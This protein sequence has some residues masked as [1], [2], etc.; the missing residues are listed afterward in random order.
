MPR[1]V[2]L[3]FLLGLS[4][5]LVSCEKPQSQP[6]PLS[7]QAGMVIHSDAIINPGIYHLPGTDS[8]GRPLV[9]IEGNGITVDFNGSEMRGSTE[10]QL[11]NQY[12]GLAVLVR[13]SRNVTIRNLKARGY[14]IALMAE[15]SDSLLLEHCDFSYNFRQRLHSTREREDLADWL[16]YHNNEA[17]EWLRYGAAVYLKKCNHATVRHLT[18]TGGQNGLMLAECNDGLFYNN[19]IHFNSGVGIGLYRSA[20]NKV[21]HNRLDWNV[22]GYS[23][24]FYSRGQDSAGILC[25]EQSS[26]NTFAYN[27]ATHSGDGFFLWAGQ[28]TMDTGKGGCNDNIIFGNDFSHAPAN[29]IEATFSRNILANNRLEDCKYG[30]WGG[31]S[32]GTLIA[33][34][35]ICENQFGVAIEHGQDN[36][37]VRNY[38]AA[39]SIGIQL[40][41]R[42]RQPEDWGFSEIKNVSSRNYEI[43]HNYFVDVK[44]PL[45]ISGTDKVAINDD[46]QFYNFEKLL[47][48]EKPNRQF[49]LVK[50]DVCQADQWGDAAGY[51]NKNRISE[52][53]LPEELAEW[54]ELARELAPVEAY[55][56]QPLPDAMDAMLPEGHVR[57]RKFILVNE[58]GP[59]DFLR[60]SIWLRDIKDSLYTFLLLGPQGNWRLNGGQGFTSVNPKT[61]AF[62]ATLTAK[63][64]ST[65]EELKL[66]FEFI[67][68]KAIGQFGEKMERGASVPFRFYRFEK[69]LDWTVRF[70]EYSESTHPLS[71]YEAFRQ[72]K[73]RKPDAEEQVQEL[74]YSWW[75]RPAPGVDADHFATFASTSFDIIP[76]KYKVSVTSDD[77]LR[78]FVDGQLVIGHWDVHE[79]ATDEAVLELSGRHTFEIEHF[80][81]GGFAALSF[82]MERVK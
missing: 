18:V 77:G 61:G 10:E 62:P 29:G 59:Y 67:G 5:V 44:I 68:E 75:E 48:A 52:P 28:S 47:L 65:G 72:L 58:W 45:Q 8:L 35:T 46:N 4:T 74:A 26:N 69:T 43:Q 15:N 56:P 7:L 53:P 25:Y 38:F 33:G 27:S 63:R 55:E 82:Y 50:N 39:D 37:I 2:L 57:G 16:S 42:D 73:E 17:D 81:A 80:D 31:Y 54:P 19:T 34:N 70:Y 32:Y 78:F 9:I 64:D 14:K 11:P 30:V 22:R 3:P 71:N 12:S 13:N 76:G 41:E 20:K 6:A 40:W 21:M 49:Y 60:P 24:G 66:E 23:H 79:P 36:A 1:S 51:K